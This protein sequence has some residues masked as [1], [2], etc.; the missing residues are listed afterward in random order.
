MPHGV[1]FWFGQTGHVKKFCPLLNSIGSVVQ[2]L[3]KPSTP[4]QDFGKS[5]I[6]PAK[7]SRS[8]TSSSSRTQGVQRP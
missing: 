4:I 2:S 6:R 1:C 7:S 3:I 8:M 5:A